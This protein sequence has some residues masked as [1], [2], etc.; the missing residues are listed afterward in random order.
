MKKVIVVGLGITGL[1][2]VDFLKNKDV[3]IFA[4][5]EN[6]NLASKIEK[7]K[8]YTNIHFI[9]GKNPTGE[10]EAN[11][12]YL[13][14]AISLD[15]NYV[16][17][18]IERDIEISNEIELAFDNIENGHIVGIT[19]TNGKTTTTMLTYEIYK[20]YYKDNSFK[21]GNIGETIIGNVDKSSGNGY[22][23]TELSSFQ[24]EIMEKFNCHI[25]S[26]LNIGMDHMNR[27]KTFENYRKAKYNIFKNQAEDDYLIINKDDE[28]IDISSEDIKSKIYYFSL[29]KISENGIYLDESDNYIYINDNNKNIKIMNSKDIHLIG[30]HNVQ[31]VMASIMMAYLDRVPLENII[32]TVEKFKAPKHRLEKIATINDVEYINDSKATNPESTIVALKSFQKNIIL[33][34]GG[35]DKKASYEEVIKEMKGKVKSLLLF[36]ETKNDI[37]KICDNM[38]FIDYIILPDLESCVRFASKISLAKDTVLLSPFC[39]SFDKYDNY[40]QRGDHFVKLIENLENNKE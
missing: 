8:N 25:A 21:C 22:Y 1:G 3:E 27:H 14:P 35:S 16:K 10:E 11:I 29:E 12:I 37:A 38:E 23:I 7:F 2:I 36:G 5:D 32:N 15:Q 33:I 24:L 6:N 18:F 13:S 31:N 40:R 28:N 30:K 19:G 4:Y 9:F 26:I 17:K 39:A 20:S 34:A